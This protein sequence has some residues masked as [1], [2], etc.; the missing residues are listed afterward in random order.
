MLFLLG[1][2]HLFSSSDIPTCA[3]VGQCG[4]SASPDDTADPTDDTGDDTNGSVDA[5][6][7]GVPASE[8]C[9]DDNAEVAPGLEEVCGDGL[10]NDCDGTPNGCRLE[11]ELDT[12]AATL[13]I[14]HSPGATTEYVGNSVAILGDVDADG[15]VDLGVGVPYDGDHSGTISIVPSD[16]GD[17]A[18]SEATVQLY[19]S[20]S[21]GVGQAVVDAGD[22]DGDGTADVLVSGYLYSG[23][24]PYG[25]AAALVYGPLTAAAQFDNATLLVRDEDYAYLGEAL[26]AGDVDGDGGT[27]VII[28]S[29]KLNG[30]FGALYVV[31]AA[32]L[33][34]GQNYVSRKATAYVTTDEE[35]RFAG[36]MTNPADLDG[37]GVAEL[38]TTAP[39]RNSYHG[40]VYIFQGPVT[41]NLTTDD[42][43]RVYLGANYDILGDKG[44]ADVPDMDGDGLPELAVGAYYGAGKTASYAGRVYIVGA[45]AN[46]GDAADAAFAT[47][48]GVTSNGMFGTRVE[49]TDFDGDGFGDVIVSA[50][51]SGTLSVF[52][53]P[54]SGTLEATDAPLTISATG[55]SSGLGLGLDAGDVNGDGVGEV[56]VG[57]PI[58][59]NGRG[60]ALLFEGASY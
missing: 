41:G 50:P 4:D 60:Q 49:G 53:G 29:T 51:E 3:T 52:Y 58:A 55:S 6:G 24:A 30:D 22:V 35:S 19:A 15:V 47:L 27:D 40:G 26:A 18:W 16:S 39:Y 25:G 23:L 31:P 32:G 37:D 38:V 56:L 33:S 59:G 44:T 12:T 28:G 48:Y 14:S 7:D 54:L 1:A 45:S 13:T 42:A 20:A 5:D 57:E 8:D 46:S 34:Q 43:G 21:V 17:M 11:G 9:D 2:C 10:D 36:P